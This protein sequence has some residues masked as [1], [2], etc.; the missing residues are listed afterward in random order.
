MKRLY[1]MRNEAAIETLVIA[2]NQYEASPSPALAERMAGYK[3]RASAWTREAAPC[4]VYDDCAPVWEARV[5]EP[6]DCEDLDRLEG[7][8]DSGRLTDR[9]IGCL[10]GRWERQPASRGRLM[11]LLMRNA[12]ASGELQVWQD[13]LSW[14]H[15]QTGAYPRTLAMGYARVLSGRGEVYASEV[16]RW[17]DVVIN[18][19]SDSNRASAKRA[20][21][22]ALTMR[23]VAQRDVV[24]LAE[25]AHAG[26]SSIETSQQLEEARARL[27]EFTAA[28]ARYCEDSGRCDPAV[29]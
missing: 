16:I 22:D 2:K 1:Q 6:R 24:L 21:V 27:A 25:R 18:R 29:P 28:R 5:I 9:E 19:A 13:L 15:N 11:D 8:A 10:K 3:Q 23:M 17:A 12:A 14:S 7:P 4:L 26:A 20:L